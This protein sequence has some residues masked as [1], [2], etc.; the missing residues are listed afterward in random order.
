MKS[1]R[2]LFFVLFIPFFWVTPS[3]AELIQ[4]T[5]V[6]AFIDKMHKEHQFDKTELEELFKKIKL[7]PEVV[8]QMKKPAEGKPWYKYRPLFV[9]DRNIRQGKAFIK[10]HHA[11][12]NKAQ[13]S[14]G[15]PAEIITAI[16][17]IESRYGANTGKHRVLDTLAT[18]AFSPTRRSRFFRKEL[19]Q[20]LLMTR[21]DN[22]DPL[23][24]HGSYAGAMGMAQFMPSS[25]QQY[26]IDFDQSGTRD[27]NTVPDAIG[28]IANY[29]QKHHWKRGNPVSTPLTAYY[30]R[31]E[32]NIRHLL[33]YQITPQ[34]K[35][36]VTLVSL[37]TPDSFEHWLVYQNFYVI[38]R[39]NHSALYAMAVFQLAEALKPHD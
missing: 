9:N 16:L 25:F 22:Q 2:Y 20:F 17:G 15:V 18:F 28:S 23:S 7:R 38:T 3:Q 30:P 14:T 35:H 34:P 27:L 24:P 12:L 1:I 4:Q 36:K 8:R 26:A 37:E 11:W 33:D 32:K 21:T 19:I 13:K 29:F 6:R 5:N 10:K 31:T 39:Y